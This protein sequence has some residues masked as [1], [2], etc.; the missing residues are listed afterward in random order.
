[1]CA[2]SMAATLTLSWTAP[3]ANTDGTA[4]STLT[5]NVYQ[6][7]TCS[8]LVLIQS[9]V[10]VPTYIIPGVAAGPYCFAV[11]AVENGVESAQSSAVSFTVKPPTPLAPTK[12]TVT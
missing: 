9:S 12:L 7:S 2:T 3:T 10:G 5:Y 1:L 8:A 11:T 6:G 4:V